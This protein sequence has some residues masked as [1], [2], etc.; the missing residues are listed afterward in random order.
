MSGGPVS[1]L[2]TLFRHLQVVRR[3]GAWRFA[4][5]A[6]Q[7]DLADAV[8]AFR[9]QEGWT[10]ILPATPEAQTEARWAWLELAVHSDLA[11]VG[12]LARIAT[13]LAAAGVPCNAVAAFHHD[14]IFVPEALA[15][16]AVSAIEE[17]RTR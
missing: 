5:S 12:F 6:Q 7:P 1:D 17:L 15:D 13:A 9:E 16:R 11:A 4:L 8:M 14:H 2:E 10:A 3:P